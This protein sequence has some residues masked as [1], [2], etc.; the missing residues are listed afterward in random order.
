METNDKI[1]ELRYTLCVKINNELGGMQLIDDYHSKDVEIHIVDPYFKLYDTIIKTELKSIIVHSPFI[2]ME[3][4]KIIT[5]EKARGIVDALLGDCKKLIRAG[6]KVEY[7][8]HASWEAGVQ[9]DNIINYVN[10]L[11]CRFGVPLLLENGISLGRQKI[12]YAVKMVNALNNKDIG[13]CID[14]AH[15]KAPIKQGENYAEYFRGI[16]NCKHIHFK[17]QDME[18]DWSN[19]NLYGYAH[20]SIKEIK[21]DL[22]ILQM[23]GVN[24]CRLCTE[25]NEIGG[26]WEARLGERKQIENVISLGIIKE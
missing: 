7:L 24:N 13:L 16:T 3:L 14:T 21:E 18:C 6:I 1:N 22:A 8:F 10:A 2:A 12:D 17:Y 11:Y 15:M 19:A 25:V 4:G 26:D 5:D 23:L 20:P 9:D